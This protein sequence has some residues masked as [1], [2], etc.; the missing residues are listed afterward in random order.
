MRCMWDRHTKG[1]SVLGRAL[2][3]SRAPGGRGGDRPALPNG[4]RAA[5][6]KLLTGGAFRTERFG[7]C[8]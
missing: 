4:S 2:L 6:R 1:R 8:C 3:S 7:R 5:G